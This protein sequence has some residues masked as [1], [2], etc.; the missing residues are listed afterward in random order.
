MPI[1][2]PVTLN[3][4]QNI[5]FQYQMIDNAT[6]LSYLSLLRSSERLAVS[7]NTAYKVMANA[8]NG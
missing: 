4:I 8:W 2:L 1:E 7:R 5:Q 6:Q 3:W